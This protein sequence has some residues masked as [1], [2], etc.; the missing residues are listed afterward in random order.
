MPTHDWG[1]TRVLPS[2]PSLI[3]LPTHSLPLLYEQVKPG[4]MMDIVTNIHSKRKTETMISF[5]Q[6]THKQEERG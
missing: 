5:Y 6:G 2:I 3:D 4:T 1:G